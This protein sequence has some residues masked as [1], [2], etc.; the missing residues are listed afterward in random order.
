LQLDAGHKVMP[1]APYH[2]P[3]PRR[4][5]ELDDSDDF[6]EGPTATFATLAAIAQPVAVATPSTPLAEIRAMLAQQRVPAIAVAD[7]HEN[8]RGVITRSEALRAIEG[9]AADVMIA[10]GFALAAG[11]TVEAAALMMARE[12]IGYV[13]IV[14]DGGR[15]V[16]VISALDVLRHFVR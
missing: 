9:V 4:I 1:L 15:L 13:I 16:G 2:R 7:D 8:L 6:E 5:E 14:G 10:G 12:S 3:S 11:S